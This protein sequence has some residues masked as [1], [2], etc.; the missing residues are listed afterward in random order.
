MRKI[1]P[2]LTAD[3]IENKINEQVEL[4]LDRQKMDLYRFII[5]IRKIDTVEQYIRRRKDENN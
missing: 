2:L 3:E 4:F 1:N 5:E